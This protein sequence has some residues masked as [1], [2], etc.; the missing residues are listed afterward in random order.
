MKAAEFGDRIVVHYIG[1]L[2]NGRIFDSRDGDSPL[3]LTLG[4]EE[5]FPALEQG[6]VG[7][8]PGE[9]KNIL[10]KPEEAF[11][12]RDDKN[13]V[14]LERSNF[15]AQREIR[16]GEKISLDFSDGSSRVMLVIQVDEERVVLDGNH[17]LAGLELTFALKLEAILS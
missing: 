7:M 1:T 17:A 15:P 14:A 11:G 9:V 5:V 6:I 12:L 10:L 3:E 4:Q 13:I 2:D 16:V 8:R